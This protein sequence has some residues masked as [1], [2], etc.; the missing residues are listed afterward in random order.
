ME[1]DGDGDKS[2]ENSVLKKSS[3]SDKSFRIKTYPSTFLGPFVVYFHKKDKP[4]NV[5]LISSEI[6]KTYKS[7]KEIKKNSLDKLRVIF[8]SREDAN[9]L[10]EFKL[11]FYL[12]R[13]YAPSDSCEIS[14]VIYDEDILNHGLGSFKNKSISSV[15]ILEC[16]RLSKLTFTDKDSFYTHSNCIKI[17]FEGSILPDYVIIDN[18]KFHVRLYFP[19]I[20]HCNRCLLFGHTANFCSNKPKCSKCNDYHS[21]SDCE[22]I[23]DVC[24]YCRGKHNSLKECSVHIAHQQKFN[25]SIKNKSK[26]SYSDVTKSTENFSS[27]YIFVPLSSIDDNDLNH[28]EN[29]FIYKPPSKRKRIHKSYQNHDPQPSTSFDINFPPLSKTKSSQ[30]IPGFKTDN[31]Y[32]KNNNDDTNN[33]NSS[34]KSENS[35]L[36]ILEDILEFLGLSDFWKKII[37]EFLPFLA[38]ILEKLNSF[39]PLISSFFAL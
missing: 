2:A 31:E 11:F 30:N 29:N 24:F 12:Y 15:K 32:T 36:S 28:E 35:I 37:K 34:N 3:S 39:G 25:Q 33:T 19:K 17:T 7:V 14:G 6:Y 20:M 16:N 9:S 1:T 13:V 4:I 21:S 23:S 18:V 5:L 22:K 27:P 10:L 8:G 26:L 38:S